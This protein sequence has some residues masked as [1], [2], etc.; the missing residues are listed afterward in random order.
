MI[1]LDPEETQSDASK[2]RTPEELRKVLSDHLEGQAELLDQVITIFRDA[3]P[4]YDRSHPEYPEL[5]GQL[6]SL[7]RL[8]FNRDHNDY[9]IDAAILHMREC[10]TL[11]PYQWHS[12]QNLAAAYEIR[13]NNRHDKQDLE[14][15]ILLHRTALSL[16]PGPAPI[17]SQLSRGLAT[18]LLNRFLREGNLA[19]MDD[20]ITYGY[21]ALLPLYEDYVVAAIETALS[22]K[23]RGF[24]RHD[25]MDIEDAI[26][27]CRLAVGCLADDDKILPI[28]LHRF[29]E[30]LLHY[31]L[32]RGNNKQLVDEAILC[33]Q[34]A[35]ALWQST[36]PADFSKLL[37]FLADA[38]RTRFEH[39][40]DMQDLTGAITLFRNLLP[41]LPSDPH[42]L[43]RLALSLQARHTLLG[44]KE[45]LNDAIAYWRKCIV[46][47]PMN[48]DNSAAMLGNLTT[49]LKKRFE[50][51]DNKLETLDE[52]IELSRKAVAIATHGEFNHRTCLHNLANALVVRYHRT[53]DEQALHEAI[54][55]YRESL[56]FFSVDDIRR[57]KPLSNLATAL[58]KLPDKKAHDEAISLHKEALELHPENDNVRPAI[59]SS[60]ANAYLS[61]YNQHQDKS[62]LDDA[63]SHARQSLELLGI[64]A[65]DRIEVLRLLA[66][67]SFAYFEHLSNQPDAD[68]S[69]HV[70]YLDGSMQYFKES[71]ESLPS[72]PF[73][74]LKIA[75]EWT[76]YARKHRHDVALDAYARCFELL[77]TCLSVNESLEFRQEAVKSVPAH[78]GLESALYALQVGDICRAVE[79][80]EQGR[81]L[82]WTHI[83][84]YR[85]QIDHVMQ[86]DEHAHELVTKFRNLSSMLS[87]SHATQASEELKEENARRYERTVSEWRDVVN[88]IRKLDGLNHFLFPAPF[89]ELQEAAYDGP[90]IIAGVRC[91]MIIVF[92]AQPPLHI[93]LPTDHAKLG[94]L[95]V[96]LWQTV[97]RTRND[98]E[99]KLRDIL[100][101]LW[102]LVV[103]P[104][105]VE[106]Q[107]VVKKRSRIWWCPTNVLSLLPLHAAGE[108]LRPQGKFLSQL[109]ISSYTPSLS[110][111]LKAR[112]HR[113]Q[114]ERKNFAAIGQ[115]QPWG[116][117]LPLMSVE[118]ELD[119]VE[120]LV[121]R[122]A[123]EFTKVGSDASTRNI[124]LRTLQENEWVH[125]SC[126]G[127]QNLQAP[128]K[129][130]FL[131]KDEPLTLLDI[132]TTDLRN[133]EFAFLSACETATGDTT[134]PEEVIHL[135]AGLHFSGVKSVIGTMWEVEDG[136]VGLLVE[137]FYKNMFADGKVDCTKAAE[138]LSKALRSPAAKKMP[139]SQ[140][141]VFIHIGI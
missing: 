71:A 21:E 7:L 35:Y 59:L 1:H 90:V 117:S 55:L 118:Q 104:V 73:R 66:L 110:A 12:A 26:E 135:A 115:A 133:H 19:D 32:Y 70:D 97:R 5:V 40:G 50:L 122:N 111:L 132:S 58:V 139:L 106:L 16:L 9:D 42:L 98:T 108:Y 123:I 95:A 81:T 47:A 92:H 46:L 76:Q 62:D 114:V 57:A 72:G 20:S 138:A 136:T 120:S 83:S 65:V 74:C 30:I 52:A 86:N 119:L 53:K 3:L 137:A 112:A 127:V 28:A 51:W 85:V 88:E 105:V 61:R 43:D 22:L 10:V 41:F 14:D 116:D 87:I 93:H 60:I 131:M 125:L 49:A 15:A 80:L 102:D 126:H 11:D 31:F 37:Y 33:C 45:D 96:E 44:D 107:K 29:A 91:E 77:A 39:W 54:L 6:G 63:D 69:D 82:L 89:S 67:I 17:K 64:N 2:Y 109:Y 141:I 34:E 128:Y 130:C 23:H 75:I 103:F 99:G 124:S 38:L 8:R 78:L 79:L 13:Y 36:T 129:S 101:Q 4:L 56:T 84:R 27:I 25:P 100:Q 140:R 48:D 18:K 24:L 94:D 134:T 121:P 68:H 113:N